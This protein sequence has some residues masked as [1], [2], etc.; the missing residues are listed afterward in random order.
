MTTTN[1]LRNGSHGAK[2]CQHQRQISHLGELTTPDQSDLF[3]LTD[4]LANVQRQKMRKSNVA[5]SVCFETGRLLNL[6]GSGSDKKWKS[7]RARNTL[8]NDK[9]IG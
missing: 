6:H 8:S 3:V 4:L 5:S 7:S 9:I 2:S 1:Q